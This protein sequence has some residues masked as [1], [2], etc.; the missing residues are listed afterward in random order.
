MSFATYPVCRPADESVS[1]RLFTP[2]DPDPQELVCRPEASNLSG[3]AGS[4]FAPALQRQK[5]LRKGVLSAFAA[6]LFK[7]DPFPRLEAESSSPW[8][9]SLGGLVSGALAGL[10]GCSGP[11]ASRPAGATMPQGAVLMSGDFRG[12]YDLLG[13]PQKYGTIF[14][15]RQSYGPMPDMDSN[16]ASLDGYEE[17]LQYQWHI[18]KSLELNRPKH[19]FVEDLPVDFPPGDRAPLMKYIKDGLGDFKNF[20]H[21]YDLPSE[22][23][24]Q[25]LRLLAAYKQVALIY[26]Y[27][28]PDVYLHRTVE[29]AETDELH[30][31]L[32]QL[33]VRHR[34]DPAAL[35]RDPEF[36]KLMFALP[37]AYAVRE[38]MKFYR[39]H[40]GETIALIFGKTNQFCDN[41]QAIHYLPRIAS[42]WWSEAT[43]S[44]TIPKAC[45]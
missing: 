26:A 43:D 23:E 36:Q 14:F 15:Y 28:Y 21:K 9:L 11:A 18:L 44:M 17:T 5:E 25:Y 29:P 38:I 39:Q 40:P 42:F 27:K 1:V 32:E 20:F 45:E 13:D 4:S 12:R 37:E 33:R 30:V 16:L 3:E 7:T 10:G 35:R 8:D 19:V 24:P 41:F 6:E 31:R 2:K 22:R 34:G